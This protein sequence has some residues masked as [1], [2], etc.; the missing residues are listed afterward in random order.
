MMEYRN[1]DEMD[2]L[3]FTKYVIYAMEPSVMP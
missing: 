1:K 3:R 2:I